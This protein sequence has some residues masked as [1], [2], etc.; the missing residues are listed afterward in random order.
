M[1]K[2]I[3][4]P[5]PKLIY[6]LASVSLLWAG[7][8]I[9]P[10]GPGIFKALFYE[11]HAP[12]ANTKPINLMSYIL[13]LCSLL[14]DIKHINPFY[15]LSGAFFVILAH[16]FPVFSPYLFLVSIYIFQS[17]QNE[18]L[19]SGF[20]PHLLA[21]TNA[22]ALIIT[23]ITAFLALQST[24]KR[25][26]SYKENSISTS[27]YNANR[28]ILPTGILNYLK[29]INYSG[30]VLNTCALDGDYIY[31]KARPQIMPCRMSFPFE[32]NAHEDIFSNADIKKLDFIVRTQKA[33]AIFISH[34]DIA[35]YKYLLT[36]LTKSARWD[37]A[38]H[39]I[40]GLLFLNSKNIK[41]RPPIAPISLPLPD[42]ADNL[43][44]A[45]IDPGPLLHA[46]YAGIIMEKPKLTR[47]ILRYI[48][49]AS[50]S[51]QVDFL[52]AKFFFNMENY[53]LSWAYIRR[54]LI[55]DRNNPAYKSM[56]ARIACKLNKKKLA[57]SIIGKD[58]SDLSILA[59]INLLLCDNIDKD[60][61]MQIVNRYINK[62]HMKNL[63]RNLFLQD[64][65]KTLYENEK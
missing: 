60:K 49:L 7:L 23:C 13:I 61:I 28:D 40:N 12:A 34:R 6:V 11:I 10:Q 20:Y 24:N 64:V 14:I 65:M 54:S 57:K 38:R 51:P 16:K 53:K 27:V 29:A 25:V 56:A 44:T 46:A 45:T 5:R 37:L 42:I 17:M 50:P 18:K 8:F 55:A 1:N 30:V 36:Y 58:T 43:G 62:N 15:L 26:F 21:L 48:Q 31:A 9:S 35:T 39:D 22:A 47:K 41:R 33:Y 19:K 3:I 63:R 32:Y 4:I 59:K 2:N 52:S